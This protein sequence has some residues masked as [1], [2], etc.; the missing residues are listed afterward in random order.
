MEVDLRLGDTARCGK[1]GGVGA[2][3]GDA[4]RPDLDFLSNG[5]VSI[6]A[7]SPWRKAFFAERALPLGVFGPVLACA[8]E[9]LACRWRSLVMYG[10]WAR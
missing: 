7:L 4:L 1:N 3:T 5:W 2:L 10:P 9:R 8:L 6:G